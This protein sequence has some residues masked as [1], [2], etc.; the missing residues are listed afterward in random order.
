MVQLFLVERRVFVVVLVQWG[1][2]MGEAV[3]AAEV[4]FEAGMLMAS[5][6]QMIERVLLV[7]LYC[8][9]QVERYHYSCSKSV[10]FH[11]KWVD[12]HSKSVDYHS[13]GY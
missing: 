12:Y 4:A 13:N 1:L 7:I 8:S 11:S 3:E 6:V 2:E 10:D 9:Q 5:L